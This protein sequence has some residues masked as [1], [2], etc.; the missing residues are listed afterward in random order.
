[1]YENKSMTVRRNIDDRVIITRKKCV[2]HYAVW[3]MPITGTI[4][5]I[6][7]SHYEG[8][9]WRPVC[10]E[11]DDNRIAWYGSWEIKSTVL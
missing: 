1:M 5:E 11:F 9:S 4:V 3:D 6:D 10:I 8:K 7:L 2:S